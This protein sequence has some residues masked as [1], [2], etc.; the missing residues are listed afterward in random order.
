[1][2]S[3]S[4]ER[5][6]AE[7]VIVTCDRLMQKQILRSNHIQIKHVCVQHNSVQGKCF[8]LMSEGGKSEQQTAVHFSPIA[9]VKYSSINVEGMALTVFVV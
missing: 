2:F 1:M 9:V 8:F 7:T 3:K 5:G 6:K 4:N